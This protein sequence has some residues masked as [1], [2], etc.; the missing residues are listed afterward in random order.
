MWTEYYYTVFKFLVGGGMVVGVTWLSRFVD[1]KYGGI[2]IAAPIVTTIAF[3][4]TYVESGAGTTRQL[5][6]ASV[7]FMVPTLVF[8]L[9][10]FLLMYRYSFFPSL[11]ASFLVWMT[12]VLVINHW[13][14]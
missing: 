9:A 7:A 11:V 6:L 8:V 13:V 4:F 12:G 5:V 14:G 2:L 10:L 3:I 1:P